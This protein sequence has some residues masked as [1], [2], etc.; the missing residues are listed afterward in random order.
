M[1]VLNSMWL[2]MGFGLFI[3]PS[4]SYGQRA[5]APVYKDGDSWRI[6]H[7]VN[8]VGFDV[9]GT[10]A[11]AYPEYLIRKDGGKANVFGVKTD[12]QVAIECPHIL[13]LVLGEEGD[14]KFPLYSGLSWSDRRSRR[15]PGLQ[16]TWV[17]YQYEVNSWE[18]IKTPKGEFDAFKIVKSF[19]I[20]PPLRKG[21][22]PHWQVH[23][24]Y[25]APSVKAIVQYRAED[26]DIKETAMLVDFSLA[27]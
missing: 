16:P 24:Y 3:Y 10:C 17:N 18:K 8:R 21:V 7:E 5:E 23:T 9:S 27:Q 22:Q 14:L 2:L 15:V 19:Q 20:S 4:S 6:R 13:T 11:Q 26:E 25:Y 1:K 12:G